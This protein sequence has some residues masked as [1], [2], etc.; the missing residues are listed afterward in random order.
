MARAPA[1]A[2][3]RRHADAGRDRAAAPRHARRAATGDRQPRDELRR[4]RRRRW[5]SRAPTRSDWRSTSAPVSHACAAG[6]RSSASSSANA[7]ATSARAA[8]RAP[9]RGERDEGDRADRQHRLRQEHGRRHG[10]ARWTW[11]SSTS[12]RSRGRS[13][14]TTRRRGGGSRRAS[15]RSRRASS[16]AIVF[17]DPARR[18]RPR[19]DPPSAGPQRDAG[20]AGRA[21]GRRRGCRLHRGDQAARVTAPRPVRQHLGR[22]LRRSRCG[23][24]GRRRPAA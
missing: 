2:A 10:C 15:G 22:A 5:A 20:A 16:P 8:S 6:G 4:L 13:G 23:A 19:G 21:G 17:S 11:R 9:E 24:P 3:R 1:S 7:A 14:T 12:T 18:C